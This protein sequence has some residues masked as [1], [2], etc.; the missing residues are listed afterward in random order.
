MIELRNKRIL[1]TG[2]ESMLGYE[3]CKLLQDKYDCKIDKCPHSEINLLDLRQVGRRFELFEPDIVIHLATYSGNIQFNQKYPY[4]TF[5]R[6]TQMALNII[7]CCETFKVD[8]VLSVLSSCTYPSI[9]DG[10][11]YENQLWLGKPHKSIESHGLAKRNVDTLTR[12]V[13][14]QYKL[15]AITCVMSNAFGP[16]DSFSI[17]KTKVVGGLIKKFIDAKETGIP[18]E[19]WGTGIAKRELLYSKDAAK[20]LV[21]CLEVY[22]DDE[23]INIGT[24]YEISIKDLAQIIALETEYKGE[25]KWLKEKGNGQLRKKLNL[26]KMNEILL[27]NEEFQYTPM[28][29]AL[30]ETISWYIDN[31]ESWTK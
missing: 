12:L 28:H 3:V 16:R 25:I 7:E 26:R 31:K 5:W 29:I 10:E 6:T 8:K 23:V 27:N 17:E 21:R 22:D 19:L 30:N 13:R 9:D 15:N 18:P 11:I 2:G 24:P 1:C 20:L 4:D 14:E